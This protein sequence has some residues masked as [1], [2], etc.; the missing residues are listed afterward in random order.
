MNR[1]KFGGMILGVGLIALLTGG[2]LQA[3]EEYPTKPVTLFVG[4]P[5]GGPSDLSARALAEAVKPFFPQPLIVVNKPGGGGVLSTAEMMKS[6]PDGYTLGHV[7]IGQLSIA[8]HLEANLP[9]KGPDDLE[10]II[11]CILAQ[12]GFAVKADAPWKTM[13][14]MVD[15]AKAN[16]GKLRVGVSGIGSTTHLHFLSLKVLGV[17]MTEVPFAGATPTVLAL[18]GGHV[19]GI[20]LNLTPVMPHVK[21]GKLKFLSLFTDER[22]TDQPELK[23]VPTLKELGYKDAITEGTS[24]FIAA[25]KGTPKRI[26]D[27]LYEAFLK[28]E[29]TDFYKKFC[30][31][32]IL[33]IELKGP[34]ELK[35]EAERSYAYYRDFVEKTGLKNMTK[36]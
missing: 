5:A 22:V 28:A 34:A 6:A 2:L 27:T 30:R 31:D 8:P 16:P 36:K 13:K 19:E 10:Y 26:L 20:V 17:P 12:N 35:K 14:E 29:K 11:S 23:D 25:P 9:Y 3:A 24:Y 7:A 18:L 21:A 33:A 4:F 1:R 15:Y 32:N